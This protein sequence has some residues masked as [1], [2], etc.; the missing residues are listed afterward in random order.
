LQTWN[1]RTL[2]V[3]FQ[4][5]FPLTDRHKIT[6]GGGFRNVD[7]CVAGGDTF[8]TWYPSPYFTTNYTNEFIQD[9]MVIIEDRLNFTL[10]CKVE[11]NPYT[12]LEY[13]PTARLLWMLDH[14]H[15]A[16]GAVSRAVR[17]PSRDLEQISLT[18]PQYAPGAYPR[19]FGN[20][21]ARTEAA[22]S[23]ELGYREQATEQFSWD[24]ALFYN[25]YD[26]LM[27]TLTGTFFLEM[28][29]SPPHLVIPLAVDSGPT[30]ETY[31]AELTGNYSVSERWCLY[32]QYSLLQLH[33]QADP[34]QST[35]GGNA[36]CNQIY[37]RSA[38][39][40]NDKLEFD[41]MARYV[42]RL[43]DL[44][45]PSYI[46]MDL[47]LAWRPRKHLEL[48]VVGQNLLEDH[49]WEYAGNSAISPA[50]ATE[51]PRGVYGTLTWRY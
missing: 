36:P 38:W 2:D 12:G 10:G 8:T 29:P 14:R 19:L 23:Y 25:A 24:I 50:Y 51:V 33:V 27:D 9:E 46:T 30:A 6:C 22:L 17:T 47:R 49:H 26:R 18:L 42:D 28:V 7:S 1:D 20:G 5:R 40:L 4:Y 21:N 39:D 43:V 32:A 34:T 48:A 35:D 37:L 11:Q 44:Q 15:S 13:E 3:D 31:G 41:M 45:V 16:W